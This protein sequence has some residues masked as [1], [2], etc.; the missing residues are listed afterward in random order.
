V[1]RGFSLIEL[2]VVMVTVALLAAVAAPRFAGSSARSRLRAAGDRLAADMEML[3]EKA[4]AG[5]TNVLVRFARAGYVW[6]L[7]NG[8]QGAES[9]RTTLEDPPYEI[10]LRTVTTGPNGEITFD[11]YG[12]SNATLAVTLGTGVY[13]L[14]YE[15]ETAG[16]K[17]VLDTIRHARGGED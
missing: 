10:T 2:V 9:G 12:G 13:R 4:R 15:I 1:K 16:G 17:G 7:T 8:G 11:G 3:R 5:S 6:S 14:D